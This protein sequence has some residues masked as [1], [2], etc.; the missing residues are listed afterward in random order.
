MLY[1]LARFVV[2]LLCLYGSFSSFLSLA[3]GQR[4]G[5]FGVLAWMKGRG[6]H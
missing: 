6:V 1:L 4:A 3:L 2:N 5:L